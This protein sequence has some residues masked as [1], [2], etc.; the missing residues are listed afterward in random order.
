MCVVNDEQMDNKLNRLFSPFLVRFMARIGF[1]SYAIYL[2]HS[3]V[4]YAVSYLPISN[5]YLQF[6][7]V[8]VLS[9]ASGILLTATVESYFLG[10][11]DTY[12]PKR[13]R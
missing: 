8:F 3:L 13:T 9:V 5:T 4:I 12:F 10:I 6:A 1:N 11:R 7:L 2:I